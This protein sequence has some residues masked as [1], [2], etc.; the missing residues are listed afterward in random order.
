[1][2]QTSVRRPVVLCADRRPSS[3]CC[4]DL[5]LDGRANQVAPLGPGAV[6][7]ADLVEA[8]EVLQDEPGM[9]GAF[10]DAAVDNGF[11]VSGLYLGSDG[12]ITTHL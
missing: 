2:Q 3:L 4:P 6:V 10:A 11:P 7:V 8:E 9:G 12:E 1:M 5:F